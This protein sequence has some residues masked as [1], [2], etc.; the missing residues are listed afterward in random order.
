METTQ[1]AEEI[2]LVDGFWKMNGAAVPEEA[3][4]YG[5]TDDAGALA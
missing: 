4:S 1:T 5:K 3:Y 2:G